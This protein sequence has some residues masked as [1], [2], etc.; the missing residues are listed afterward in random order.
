MTTSLTPTT[1]HWATENLPGSYGGAMG[2][3]HQRANDV[4][5]PRVEPTYNIVIRALE[6][7]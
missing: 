4:F 6:M 7:A 5:R 3:I 1:P 2:Q